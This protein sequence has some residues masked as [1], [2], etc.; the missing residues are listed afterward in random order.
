M[1]YWMDS[2]DWKCQR[3]NVLWDFAD[4]Y[5][6]ISIEIKHTFT[7]TETNHTPTHVYIHLHDKKSFK[8]HIHELN[9]FLKL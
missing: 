9:Y 3:K 1:T 4:Y 8:L 6:R 5:I 2:K 7:Y